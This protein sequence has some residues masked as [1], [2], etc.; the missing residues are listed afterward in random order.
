MNTVSTQNSICMT[1]NNGKYKLLLKWKVQTISCSIFK[2]YWKWNCS[3]L[4]YILLDSLPNILNI[5]A[6]FHDCKIIHEKCCLLNFPTLLSQWLVLTGKVKFF[7][8]N[9]IFPYCTS[10]VLNILQLTSASVHCSYVILI[11][12]QT[13]T[14]F[15]QNR[16]EHPWVSPVQIYRPS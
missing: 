4:F 10:V 3:V 13:L 2:F 16:N 11:L 6:L 15:I 1:S 14:L 8:W 5:T 9:L 12:T 7:S